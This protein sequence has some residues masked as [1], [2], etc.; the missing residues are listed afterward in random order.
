MQ[1]VVSRASSREETNHCIDYGFL[2]DHLTERRVALPVLNIAQHG[3][4]RRSREGVP[5]WVIRIHKGTAW[6]LQSH[7]LKQHL[8]AVCGPIEGAGTRAVVGRRL[9][10]NEI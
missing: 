3:L 2:A 1:G 4:Y 8:I 6:Q 7:K 5:C 10:G 9:C